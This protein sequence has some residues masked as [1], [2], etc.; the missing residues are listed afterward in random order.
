MINAKVIGIG[1]AGNKAAI[2][3]IEKG[4]MSRQNVLLLNSTLKDVP[5]A[6]KELAISFTDDGKGCG[7]E[8]GLAKDIALTALKSKRIP[9]QNLLDPED[10][11]LIIVNSS[12]GGTGSGASAI[13]S[14]YA[15]AVL[16]TN[17]HRFVFTGFEDDGKGI[18]NTLEYFQ[19][20]TEDCAVQAI[21]N[22]KFLKD[23]NGNKLAAQNLA[24]E[25]FA[26]R[27]QILLG[28]IIV[29]S[30]NNID[31]ADLTKVSTFPGFTTI[32][33][34]ELNDVKNIDMFNKTVSDII[35]N[36]KSLNYDPS[37]RKLAVILNVS[38]KTK[39]NVDYSF[40]VIK[41]KLGNSFEVYTHVQSELE[42]EYIA[43]IASGMKMPIDE[44]KAIYNRFEEIRSKLDQSRDSF[45]DMQLDLTCDDGPR[46]NNTPSETQMAKAEDDFFKN[47]ESPK[48]EEPAESGK[49]INTKKSNSLKD[50]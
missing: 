7:K 29:D 42:P 5:A 25:E 32:E 45:F 31:D 2:T 37:A 19:N 27:V 22:A 47:F 12:E 35:D 21:S 14:Q 1:A 4:I 40:K 23:A 3:L 26:K 43:I 6:Y 34:G 17:V 49:F 13:I 33:Y 28:H 20:V 8:T 41:D 18:K 50:Y 10:K 30:E 48:T 46:N 24:N 38:E 36:S 16:K 44:V 15:N 39:S 11:I 9:I